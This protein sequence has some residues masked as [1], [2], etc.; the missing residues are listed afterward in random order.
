MEHRKHAAQRLD[1]VLEARPPGCDQE[2]EHGGR[3]DFEVEKGHMDHD[4]HHMNDF[5]C[6]RCGACCTRY[7]WVHFTLDDL[8]KLADGLD[9]PVSTTYARYCRRVRWGSLW[10]FAINV[11]G[12]CPFYKGSAGCSV[13]DAR[14]QICRRYPF[15]Y[16]EAQRVGEL[17]RFGTCALCDMDDDARVPHDYEAAAIFEQWRTFTN[18]FLSRRQNF[19]DLQFNEAYEKGVMIVNAPA[20]KQATIN[21]FYLLTRL[22]MSF[23]FRLL[24]RMLF[25]IYGIRGAARAPLSEGVRG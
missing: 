9:L 22:R 25:F 7:Q 24:A 1:G 17:Q 20:L 14:S 23:A 2:H 16:V 3:R 18:E 8:K 19:T 12:G 13:Y 11:E 6:S 15:T 5:K 21:S 10:S 4:R